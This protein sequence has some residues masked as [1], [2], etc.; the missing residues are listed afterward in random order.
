MLN[1][2][3]AGRGFDDGRFSNFDVAEVAGPLASLDDGLGESRGRDELLGTESLDNPLGR[4]NGDRVTLGAAILRNDDETGESDP[5]ADA[6]CV[7]CRRRTYQQ[8]LTLGYLQPA[9]LV[10]RTG[11]CEAE[12]RVMISLLP[13]RQRPPACF[14]PPSRPR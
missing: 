2:G 9:Q 6:K 10:F 14:P 8:L 3:L 11:R 12:R 13:R 5:S 7:I 4:C 1:V